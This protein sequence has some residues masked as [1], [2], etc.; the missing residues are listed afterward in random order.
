MGA[1]G[2]RWSDIERAPP[3]D[4]PRLLLEAIIRQLGERGFLPPAGAL[5]VREITR[6]ARL[7]DADDRSRLAEIAL[8]AEWVRYSD[9]RTQAARMQATGAATFAARAGDAEVGDAPISGAEGDA[10][11]Q[12]IARGRELLNRLDTDVHYRGANATRALKTSVPG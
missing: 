3:R 2:L 1:V 5:T 6:A 10:L 4:R 8:A 11:D 12:P 9:S 7:P